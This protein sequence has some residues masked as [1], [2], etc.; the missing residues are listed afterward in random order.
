MTSKCNAKPVVQIVCVSI[1][2]V[3]GELKVQKKVAI[4]DW[5]LTKFPRE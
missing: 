3:Y 1:R 4:S 5:V 2:L